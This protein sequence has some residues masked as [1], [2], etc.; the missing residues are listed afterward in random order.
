MGFAIQQACPNCGS[1]YWE[2][3]NYDGE[4]EARRHTPSIS[5]AKTGEE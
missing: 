2:W 5:L 4:I 3:T 1:P